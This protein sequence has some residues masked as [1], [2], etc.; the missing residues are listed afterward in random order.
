MV[1]FSSSKK[2]LDSFKFFIIFLV[3]IFSNRV[4]KLTSSWRPFL[5]TTWL[6]FVSDAIKEGN[7]SK[8]ELEGL[9]RKIAE[10]WKPL[11]RRLKVTEPELTAFDEENKKYSEKPYK[12]LLHWQ[13]RDGKDATYTVL[14][15]ALCDVL[16]KRRD[17]AQEY[18]CD[19]H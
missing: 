1:F 14:Y 11:G 10:D 13:Q 2:I 6:F 12:M 18:C 3:N 17:L 9:S 5:Y 16:V 15:N 7:P 19:R 4:F 8:D